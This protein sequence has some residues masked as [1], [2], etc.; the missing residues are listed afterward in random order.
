MF[1]SFLCLGFYL[2]VDCVSFFSL[3]RFPP[4]R[5]LYFFLSI[6]WVWSMLFLVYADVSSFSL[7]G[8]LPYLCL[9]FF[10]I[11]TCFLLIPAWVW[12]MFLSVLLPFLCVF[13]PLLLPQVHLHLHLNYFWL[14]YKLNAHMSLLRSPGQE[15]LF[16]GQVAY[17]MSPHDL[18]PVELRIFISTKLNLY[19]TMLLHA[20]FICI[21]FISS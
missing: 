9:Y 19:T 10:L 4:Y 1:L 8:F 17:F 18:K 3:L 12:S 2:I 13:L 20:L 7:P 21:S 11:S 5:C 15:S 6:P 14:N 16:I